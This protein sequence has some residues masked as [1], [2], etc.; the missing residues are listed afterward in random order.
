MRTKLSGTPSNQ[1]ITGIA[2]SFRPRAV[3]GRWKAPLHEAYRVGRGSL[4][5][6]HSQVGG[7]SSSFYSEPFAR[8]EELRDSEACFSGVKG[9][10]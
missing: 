10:R 4:P 1:R 5:R 7:W 3:S 8:L 6:V 9:A 2:I